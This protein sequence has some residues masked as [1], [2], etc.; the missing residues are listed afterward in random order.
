MKYRLRTSTGATIDVWREQDLF[1]ARRGDEEGEPQSCWA[2]D[3]FEVIADLADLDLD[4][5]AQAAEA[6]DL[7][8]RAH[9]GLHA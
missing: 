1:H 3:L 6:M 8:G 5:P 4:D 9:Q 7:A 2:V